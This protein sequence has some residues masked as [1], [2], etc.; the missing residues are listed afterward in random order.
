MIY[1][2]LMMLV[3]FVAFLPWLRLFAGRKHDDSAKFY[4]YRLFQLNSTYG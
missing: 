1:I 3:A 2:L 4:V